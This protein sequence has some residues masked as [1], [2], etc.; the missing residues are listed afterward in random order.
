MHIQNLN[1]AVLPISAWAEGELCILVIHCFLDF[2]KVNWKR[3]HRTVQHGKFW[4]KS[5]ALE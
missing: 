5:L 1:T 4:S 3:I 2:S